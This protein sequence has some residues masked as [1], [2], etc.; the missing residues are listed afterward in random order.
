[1]VELAVGLGWRL[2]DVT[3]LDGADLA[4]LVAVLEARRG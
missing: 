4:T 2:E 1:M 3:A